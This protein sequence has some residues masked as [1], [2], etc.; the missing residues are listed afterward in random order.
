MHF[1]L[2][3]IA[4]AFM[5]RGNPFSPVVSFTLC[6]STDS[7]A[8]FRG[9]GMTPLLQHSCHPTKFREEPNLI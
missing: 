1:A 9:L 8:R 5:A 2:T 3:V 7:H 4:S 6:R